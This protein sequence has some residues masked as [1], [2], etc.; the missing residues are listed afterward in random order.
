MSDKTYTVGICT[1]EKFDNRVLNSVGS[2]RI[3]ARW[4]LNYW[5]EA[6]EFII[7]K[8]YDVLIFQ[9]VYWPNMLK[10]YEGI[11]IFDLCD[12]DWL[13]N[14][15][16][17]EFIDQVDAVTT[18]TQALA[19]YIKKLR[20]KCNVICIPDRVLMPEARPVKTDYG[21]EKLQKVAW[22]GYAQN[23]RYLQRAYDELVK[24]NLELVVIADQPI[25]VPM[26]YKKKLKITNVA[27]NY[28]TVNKELIKYDAVLMPSPFGDERAKYKSNNK[29]LQAWSLGLPVIQHPDDIERLMTAKAREE[30][31]KAR[32]KEIEEKWDCKISVDEYRKL[33]EEIATAKKTLG[34]ADGTGGAE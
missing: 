25:D 5:P 12:P 8:K 9:K 27:Y 15:P 28:Q 14:K 19:D 20:P 30:E 21:T 4:L 10:H 17:F 6:E 32:R 18:S 7:G 29:T 22:F 23:S 3:R 1:M 33:I 34:F 26:A 13:E 2:S 31:G 24:H 11:K 16:V